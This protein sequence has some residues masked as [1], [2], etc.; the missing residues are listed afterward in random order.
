MRHLI[1]TWLG[2]SAKKSKKKKRRA[3]RQSAWLR[4]ALYATASISLFGAIAGTGYWVWATGAVSRMTTAVETAVIDGTLQAGLAV[5]EILVEGRMETTKGQLLRTLGVRR[6]DPIL[7]FD[8]EAARKRLIKLGWVA[9]AI[10]ERHLPD[11][12]FVRIKERKA[13]AVWQR[14][15]SLVLID[16]DGVVI[17]TQGLNQYTHL[18]I[19][20]G[21]DAPR[22]TPALLDMLSIA[23]P[24]MK[25][26]RAAIWVGGRRWNLQLDDGIDIRLPEDNPQMAWTRLATLERNQ[27]LLSQDIIAVDLRIQDRLVVRRRGDT[28][29]VRGNST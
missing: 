11:T 27:Q 25:R 19:I 18:K 16:R 10:V 6:G 22:H 8:T 12:V 15:G 14:K 7:T 4:P 9:D 5:D 24:L 13:M 28:A 20:V 3:K 29:K 21:D 1:P 17:G 2:G 23:P 26:V